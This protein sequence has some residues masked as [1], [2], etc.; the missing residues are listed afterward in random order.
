MD[1]K[2]ILSLLLCAAS[3]THGMETE[4]S[5]KKNEKIYT[6]FVQQNA[7]AKKIVP[8]NQH[9]L[10]S[11][12]MYGNQHNDPDFIQ[13]LLTI[14]KPLFEDPCV[15]EAYKHSSNTEITRILVNYISAERDKRQLELNAY[16]KKQNAHI[17]KCK[18]EQIMQTQ[19]IDLNQPHDQPECRFIIS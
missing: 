9:E 15:Q 7:E 19:S 10:T 6:L 16:A 3:T 5:T 17:K 12:F 18:D 8:H 1:Y 2:L 14:R 11:L 4:E 13:W